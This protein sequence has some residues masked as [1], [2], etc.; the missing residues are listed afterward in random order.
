[1]NYVERNNGE[2][3]IVGDLLE[4]WHCRFESILSAHNELFDCLAE[5]DCTYILGNHDE[6]LANL[7]KSEYLP[8]RL[9]DKISPPVVRTL[10]VRKFKFMHGHEVDPF[11]RKRSKTLCQVFSPAVD[12][13]Q[14]S[15]DSATLAYDICSDLALELGEAA[16]AI[17]KWL[18]ELTKHAADDCLSLLPNE[19]RALLK[20]HSRTKKMLRR[21]R[22]DLHGGLYDVAVVGH[23]HK[24]G[25]FSDWYFNSGSWT[26]HKNNFLCI[27]PDGDVELFDWGTFGPQPNDTLIGH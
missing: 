11:I 17:W 15:S 16:L 26:A 23:T 22:E 24:A 4:L 12:M 25:R 14:S 10:G 1:L 6:D 2:L 18:S 9:F 20:R 8:H 5:T 19:E 13:L 7:Q 27:S 21:Y 3:L